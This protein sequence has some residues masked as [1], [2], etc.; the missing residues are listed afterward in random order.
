MCECA[1]VCVRVLT[2]AYNCTRV[3]SLESRVSSLVACA[4]SIP[5]SHYAANASKRERESCWQIAWRLTHFTT[6]CPSTP[7]P[8]A[9]PAALHILC[10]STSASHQVH[11]VPNGL[12]VRRR[13]HC[14]LGAAPPSAHPLP[15]V[16]S[17]FIFS[18]LCGNTAQLA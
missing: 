9:S 5:K 12:R 7:S 1:L 4:Q 8:S 16:F 14:P 18:C 10:A 15:I 11:C 2:V 3:C 17:F 6:C 13:R